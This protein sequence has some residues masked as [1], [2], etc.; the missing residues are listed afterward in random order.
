MTKSA[1]KVVVRE[2]LGY[3]RAESREWKESKPG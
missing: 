2:Y 3:F 1:N